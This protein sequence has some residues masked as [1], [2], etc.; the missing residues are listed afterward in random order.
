M[1]TI[2]YKHIQENNK[3]V[4]KYIFFYMP[5]TSQIINF[6]SNLNLDICRNS[7]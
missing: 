1:L 6:I 5:N 2:W 3:P 7:C 4:C